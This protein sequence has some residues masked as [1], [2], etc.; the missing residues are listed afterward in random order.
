M[1]FIFAV[2]LTLS[3]AIL[4]I[5]NPNAVTTTFSSAAGK[6]VSL[7]VTLLI[8]YSVWMGFINLIE[9]SE[10]NKKI[11][12]FLTPIIKFLFRTNDEK[13]ISELA[14][15]LSA[16]LL[17]IGGVA[18]PSGINAMALLDESKNEFGKNMLFTITATSIQI[19]PITVIALMTEYGSVNPYAVF[20]P[21]L[22]T[23]F[24][25]TLFGVILV[26]ITK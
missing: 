26:F 21:T 2:I 22:L 25:S 7:S 13:T 9:T 18:T 1:N 16:N 8:V 11:S 20:L 12:K 5:I 6:A 24:L 3:L 23:T 4:T 17:G 15:N 14:I 19:F 10:L